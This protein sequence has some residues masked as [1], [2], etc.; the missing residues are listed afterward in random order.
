[1]SLV[2]N[3][4]KRKKKGISRTKKNTTVS[5]KAYSDTKK[6]WPKKKG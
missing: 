6:G 1:M 5:K 3:I 4:N 2:E